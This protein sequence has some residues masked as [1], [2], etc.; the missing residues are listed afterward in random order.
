MSPVEDLKQKSY[1]LCC[2]GGYLNFVCK[3]EMV[4]GYQITISMTVTD[5][6][7]ILSNSVIARTLYWY[8]Q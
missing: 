8:M 1:L 7:T 6:D 3:F 5:K 4:Y 2:K